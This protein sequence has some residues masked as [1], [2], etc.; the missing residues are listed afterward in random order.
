MS[1][2][3]A[4]HARIHRGSF[5]FIN[6][7]NGS[8][9]H[10]SIEVFHTGSAEANVTELHANTTEEEARAQLLADGYTEIDRDGKPVDARHEILQNAAALAIID[11]AIAQL[12]ALGIAS[13]NQPIVS[14]VDGSTG[15]F[16]IAAK[17]P[18]D[19][20]SLRAL[21]TAGCDS[22]GADRQAYLKALR[23]IG[24]IDQ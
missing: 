19:V 23:M 5:R 20:T 10:R 6:V 16:L 9:N 17:T 11:N 3:S 2:D 18:A 14:P 4:P 7:N 8:D 13:L 1:I 21:L 15:W 22:C 12:A 24:L